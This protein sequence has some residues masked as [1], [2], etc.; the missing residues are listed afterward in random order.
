MR[1]EAK[2]KC[3]ECHFALYR[4]RPG[5]D[6]AA[7]DTKGRTA[8]DLIMDRHGRKLR[9]ALDDGQVSAEGR[10]ILAQLQKAARS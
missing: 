7:R 9:K 3:L 8:W 10:A 1:R 5:V 6:P 4:N 2:T